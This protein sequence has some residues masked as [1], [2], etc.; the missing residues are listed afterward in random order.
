MPLDFGQGGFLGALGQGLR[1]AGAVFSPQVYG[2]QNEEER[3]LMQ[4][5]A[6]QQRLQLETIVQ[7]VR[8]GSISPQDPRAQQALQALG[9]GGLGPT[10]R[11]QADQLALKEHQRFAEWAGQ[12]KGGFG[13]GGL[14]D[15]PPEVA[16][17][18]PFQAWLKTQIEAKNLSQPR[19]HFDATSGNLIRSYPDGRTEVVQA[20]GGRGKKETINIGNDMVR[21]AL[22]DSQ[23]KVIQWLGEPSHKFAR[24]VA[25]IINMGDSAHKPPPGYRWK[26]KDRTELEKIPGGPAEARDDKETG[27]IIEATNKAIERSIKPIDEV[28]QQVTKVKELLA[29]D[30][31]AAKKQV[32]E[33]LTNVFDRTRATNLLF[34]EN[35]NFGTLAGRVTGG[36]TSFVGGKYSAEQRKQIKEMMDEME[37][38]VIE[39]QRKRITEYYKGRAQKQYGIN[40]DLIEVPDFYGTSKGT[41]NAQAEADAFL[42]G[43]GGAGPR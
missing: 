17:S 40:P 41:G 22:V 13:S 11:A 36:I 23:G 7:G 16:T 33:L 21:D 20:Q 18:A 43:L 6:Q 34:K 37:K 15:V 19:E 35:A 3:L 5:R 8:E 14:R 26:D 28:Q 10:P 24:Q 2:A 4:I 31:P 42:K 30:T 38:N 1:G 32:T 27:R 25:P 12:Q 9:V 39:P 29:V